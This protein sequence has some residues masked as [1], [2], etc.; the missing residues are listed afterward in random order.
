M[1]GKYYSIR[2]LTDTNSHSKNYFAFNFRSGFC[3]KIGGISRAA[4][5]HFKKW[6]SAAEGSF[7]V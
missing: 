6:T 2:W 7:I 4:E 5:A 1:K 3:F